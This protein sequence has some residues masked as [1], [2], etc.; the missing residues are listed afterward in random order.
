MVE[1]MFSL[2]WKNLR[3]FIFDKY[4][5]HWLLPDPSSPS[6]VLQGQ[7]Y[8]YQLH[9]LPE[10]FSAMDKMLAFP[11][12][13]FHVDLLSGSLVPIEDEI[14][15]TKQI[16]LEFI[17]VQFLWISKILTYFRDRTRV[18]FL[19]NCVYIWIRKNIITIVKES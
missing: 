11:F 2:S 12:D 18:K 15:S 14:L 7:K 17:E 13:T 8:L 9:C 19:L 1:L 6:I 4:R 5:K 3:C 16:P 10:A